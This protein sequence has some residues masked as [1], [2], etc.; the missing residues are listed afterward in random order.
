MCFILTLLLSLYC[1]NAI[2][3]LLSLK[4]ICA[5]LSPPRDEKGES[6]SEESGEYFSA[7]VQG[8]RREDQSPGRDREEK[9][10]Q[11]AVAKG[12]GTE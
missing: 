9:G 12:Q 11:C 6:L 8:R 5:W 4:C 1:I 7:T 10:S 2:D 3:L